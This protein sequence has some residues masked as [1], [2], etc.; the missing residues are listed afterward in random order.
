MT[1]RVVVTGAN[2]GIGLELVRS[3]RA[4]GADVWGGC[5]RP[6]EADELRALTDHVHM[7]DARS[8]DSIAAF[9]AAVGPDPVDVLVNNAGID[10]RVLGVDDAERDVLQLSGQHFLAEMQ[11]NAVAPMLLTRALL[12]PLRR[13]SRPR[14]VNVSSQVGSMVVAATMGRDIGYVASKAALNMITVKQALHLRDDG[15]VVIALHPGHLK[16]YLGGPRAPGDVAEAAVTITGLIGRLEPSD[17]G[18]FRQAD[19]S[20]HPW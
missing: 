1:E 5:R 2:R 15:I 14:V 16:T 8:D 19:G 10:A 6:A 11:V 17:S 7:F 9:A 4:R 13:S 18:T 20:I 12:E 3:F